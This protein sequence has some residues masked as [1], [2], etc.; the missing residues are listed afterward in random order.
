MLNK[1]INKRGTRS[2]SR[3]S[4]RPEV[5]SE[6]RRRSSAL[7]P[8]GETPN[9]STRSSRE[10]MLTSNSDQRERADSVTK[11]R[12]SQSNK[13]VDVNLAN[14]ARVSLAAQSNPDLSRSLSGKAALH[15]NSP[16][17][18]IFK[19]LKH[20]IKS[21]SP[22][23]GPT[24]S[25]DASTTS[26]S[27]SPSA[28]NPTAL[29]NVP[30]KLQQVRTEQDVICRICEFPVAAT[31]IERHSRYCAAQQECEMRR[32]DCDRELN[33]IITQ[34]NT[35]TARDASKS[36][37]MVITSI[38]KALGVKEYDKD[39]ISK[40]HKYLSRVTSP[41]SPVVDAADKSELFS[42]AYH[43]IEGKLK[44][45]QMYRDKVYPLLKV[46]TA[47]A[48]AGST[49]H[50]TGS[51]G[52][53]STQASTRRRSRLS[54][55]EVKG[56]S[57]VSRKPFMSLFSAILKSQ[58]SRT[59]SARPEEAAER[60]PSKMP[61]IQDFEIV[62]PVSKGAYGKVYI[63]RKK[64]TGDLY[65]IKI[66]KKE[67]MVRKNMVSHVLAE[68]KVMSLSQAPFIVKLYYAF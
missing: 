11:L 10:S 31:E 61:S 29:P 17:S 18:K 22:S 2:S 12:S 1:I 23:S 8:V 67:D 66:L 55:S 62:K 19:S 33:K 48:A 3:S 37:V 39:A 20:A 38:S 15:E 42:K 6:S 53:N 43:I 49:R 52:S 9:K 59:P 7:R 4:M 47:N 13:I 35:V 68:R 27:M 46:G 41:A 5:D 26:R 24:D 50:R 45:A 56:E 32:A 63:G 30:A 51:S 16:F 28:A 64:T 34:L 36:D 65:A 57:A 58:R 40:I 14:L 25:S 60:S 54:E 44:V 21:P